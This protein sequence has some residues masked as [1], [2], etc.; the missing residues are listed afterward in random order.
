MESSKS[1]HKPC[2]F[3]GSTNKHLSEVIL[4][5]KNNNDNK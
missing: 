3:V 4:I 1:E 5:K 2:I